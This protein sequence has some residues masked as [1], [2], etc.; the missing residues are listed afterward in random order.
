MFVLSGLV[1][2]SCWNR[3]NCVMSVQ[4]DRGSGRSGLRG[5]FVASKTRSL[6]PRERA[7]LRLGT[8]S[9]RSEDWRS[10]LLSVQGWVQGLGFRV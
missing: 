1:G 2:I 5:S 9:R 8:S 3:L 10:A 4:E 7:T 6:I